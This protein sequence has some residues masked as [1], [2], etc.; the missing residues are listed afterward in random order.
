MNVLSGSGLAGSCKEVE[1]DTLAAAAGCGARTMDG[2]A[3]AAADGTS[4]KNKPNKTTGKDELRNGT[5]RKKRQSYFAVVVAA[6]SP[7]FVGRARR[8]WVAALP[9]SWAAALAAH[10]QASVA[11]AAV[12]HPRVR[13]STP[14]WVAAAAV[15]VATAVQAH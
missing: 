13:P 9:S 3:A 10:I 7:A 1:A 4:N 11:A 5:W 6:A 2:A 12:A 14:Y 15:A 8:A